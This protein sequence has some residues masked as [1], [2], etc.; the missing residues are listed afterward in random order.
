[1]N[2]GLEEGIRNSM[3]NS[4]RT[5][6]LS[7]DYQRQTDEIERLTDEL[8]AILNPEQ[9]RM[10]MILIDTISDCDARFASEAYTKG[11]AEGIAF[12]DKFLQ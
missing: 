11:V 10:F 12:R 6:L 8:K 9:K 3:D 7:E 5:Y 2:V 1:M 4:M